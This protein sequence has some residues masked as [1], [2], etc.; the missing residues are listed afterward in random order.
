M[1]F[2]FASLAVL[3]CAVFAAIHSARG[4][5]TGATWVAVVGYVLSLLLWWIGNADN[6]N[7][8]DTPIQ[9]TAPTGGDVSAN[10]N[11]NL[12]GFKV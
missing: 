3:V 11:G 5:F 10:A 8:L 7:L 9:P 1:F 12:T 6:A 4:N 2:A